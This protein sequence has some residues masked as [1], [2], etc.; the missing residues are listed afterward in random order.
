MV[1]LPQVNAAAPNMTAQEAWQR[2]ARSLAEASKPTTLAA[3]LHCF[4]T[5]PPCSLAEVLQAAVCSPNCNL[6]CEFS[7]SCPESRGALRA[8]VRGS[9]DPAV[10][11]AGAAV[12]FAWLAAEAAEPGN[13]ESIPTEGVNDLLSA[14]VGSLLDIWSQVRKDASK[15]FFTLLPQL[16][17]DWV[18]RAAHALQRVLSMPSASTPAGSSASAVDIVCSVSPDWRQLEGAVLALAMMVKRFDVETPGD[19]GGAWGGLK[20][21]ELWQARREKGAIEPAPTLCAGLPSWLL[22]AGFLQASVL[23]L[24]AHQQKTLRDTAVQLTAS[25]VVRSPPPVHEHVLHIMLSTLI[26]P[27]FEGQPVHSMPHPDQLLPPAH[28]EGCLACLVLVLRHRGMPSPGPEDMETPGLWQRVGRVIVWY[29]G[30]AAST[31]R[32]ACSR[33]A[34]QAALARVHGGGANL[35]LR[36]HRAQS[37]QRV[38]GVLVGAWQQLV[39]PGMSPVAGGDPGAAFL[40]PAAWKLREGLLFGYELIAHYLIEDHAKVVGPLLA[41]EGSVGPVPANADGDHSSPCLPQH[42]VRAFPFGVPG[43]S[44][45]SQGTRLPL[46]PP[47]SPVRASSSAFST[48]RPSVST[49]RPE[50][51]GKAAPS[52][53]APY[54]PTLDTPGP[55]HNVSGGQEGALDPAWVADSFPREVLP[56]CEAG[57]LESEAAGCTAGYHGPL[58]VPVCVLSAMSASPAFQTALRHLVRHLQ[59][60]VD[61][62]VF[63]LRRMGEQLLP[64]IVDILLW[65][66]PRLLMEL[67]STLGLAIPLRIA[68]PVLTVGRLLN[69]ACRRAAS[70]RQR[71]QES[72]APPRPLV[73]A[74]LYVAACLSHALGALSSVGVRAACAGLAVRAPTDKCL[75]LGLDTLSFVF[76]LD[77]PQRDAPPPAWALALPLHVTL[78]RLC[79]VMR[80]GSVLQGLGLPG[81]PVHAQQA[82]RCLIAR[83]ASLRGQV[84]PSSPMPMRPSTSVSAL[85]HLFSRRMLPAWYEAACAGGQVATLQVGGAALRAAEAAQTPSLVYSTLLPAQS[86]ASAV[87]ADLST[88][89]EAVLVSGCAAQGSAGKQPLA[90]AAAGEGDAQTGEILVRHQGTLP[91]PPQSTDFM[92]LPAAAAAT[93]HASA[94][95]ASS[96]MDA[97]TPLRAHR[98]SSILSVSTSNTGEEE[99]RPLSPAAVSPP[100]APPPQAQTPTSQPPPPAPTLTVLPPSAPQPFSIPLSPAVEVVAA[101]SS[102]AMTRARQAA[103]L[104]D[105]AAT[106]A[107]QSLVLASDHT[108]LLSTAEACLLAQ[109]AATAALRIQHQQLGCDAWELA[110]ACLHE[111]QARV[112]EGGGE[113]GPAARAPTSWGRQQVLQVY[114]VAVAVPH[115]PL[116]HAQPGSLQACLLDT[117][118]VVV[119]AAVAT[120]A[121]STPLEVPDS[122]PLSL[123]FLAP[124]PVGWRRKDLRVL[125]AVL[126]AG[127]A[128]VRAATA[129]SG[130]H[131]GGLAS[132]LAHL[133]Q[134]AVQIRLEECDSAVQG[135]PALPGRTATPPPGVDELPGVA[136]TVEPS[137]WRGRGGGSDTF[138]ASR[139]LLALAAASH[140]VQGV[141]GEDAGADA[142]ELRAASMSSTGGRDVSIASAN[143]TG[144]CQTGAAQVERPEVVAPSPVQE[145]D[146]DGGGE[147]DDWDDWDEASSHSSGLSPSVTGSELRADS[148]PLQSMTGH[149]ECLA[150][151]AAALAGLLAGGSAAE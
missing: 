24:L 21:P 98:A 149:A 126:A 48:P 134:G 147:W 78:E 67:A 30:H 28:A 110:A 86:Q 33:V 94:A 10:R 58:P 43:L 143:S 29:A 113:L 131:P 150:E 35:P 20:G 112:T 62:P 54:T 70:V 37:V 13:L 99:E 84:D 49:H 52:P 117:C 151:A 2:V 119:V 138:H 23:P 145:R 45:G 136:V 116:A 101:R 1:R 93:P 73:A 4:A 109:L 26:S 56:S 135:S 95:S 77:L 128:G 68:D 64:L 44:S 132:T 108:R 140:G 61:C 22:P 127:L 12:L 74:D 80:L 91:C 55:R 107:L 41:Q 124:A 46:S 111:L 16:P 92:R 121:P 87:P 69:S 129:L 75:A 96:A 17:L 8:V 142:G 63:E 14:L 38:L 139:H 100:S 57:E 42:A 40:S 102:E 105:G 34:L 9:P 122:P 85:Q 97:D 53:W 120:L 15:A 47:R 71:L 106:A 123:A 6:L 90:P 115:S 66:A 5:P 39:S 27:Q 104:L 36:L 3:A 32:Q 137:L 11:R 25:V 50:P 79:K 133:L 76:W 89:A 144:K 83:A 82:V 18:R 7:L 125:Q 88:G 31:V 114:S 118:A 141:H 51:A 146:S 19:A 59:L 130:S 65:A 81:S 148:L 72:L 60:C 103:V